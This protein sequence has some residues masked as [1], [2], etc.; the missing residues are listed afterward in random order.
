MGDDFNPPRES[1][2]KLRA[3]I[4]KRVEESN[5]AARERPSDSDIPRLWWNQYYL[6]QSYHRVA[7]GFDEYDH[8][9]GG[10]NRHEGATCF[11]C[12]QPLQLMW[13]V[14]ARDP[15]FSAEYAGVFG[16]LSRLPLYYCCRCPEQPFTA[17]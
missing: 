6:R 14:N 7:A 12:K 4:E 13:D 3:A 1:L 11:S 2:D 15:R 10:P 9:E 8:W 16:G 17:S 5:K